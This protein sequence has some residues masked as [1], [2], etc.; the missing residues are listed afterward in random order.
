[1]KKKI[2]S[3]IL[4]MSFMAIMFVGCGN[5][6]AVKEEESSSE[7]SFISEE[8][9]I[10]EEV[11]E[12]NSETVSEEINEEAVEVDYSADTVMALCDELAE[13]YVYDDPEY[14]KSLVIAGNLDYITEEDLNT[15]LTTWGYTMEDL[16]AIYEE[17]IN[18]AAD[19]YIITHYHKEG[20]AIEFNDEVNYANR[21]LFQEVLLNPKDKE[22]AVPFDEC[23]IAN[24]GA[25]LDEFWIE[26]PTTSCEA[27]LSAVSDTLPYGEMWVTPYADYI[28]ED[29]N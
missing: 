6:D 12:E 18:A 7:N 2:L 3:C 22:L 25:K 21:I 1:M 20:S 23:A 11:S 8:S 28:Q 4:V 16:A 17:G 19:A 13:K 9:V 15:I 5:E 14:I 29:V 10:S 27:L 24:N 26:E